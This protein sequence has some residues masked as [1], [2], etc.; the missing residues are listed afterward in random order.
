MIS[1]ARS[2]CVV[3]SQPPLL[4]VGFNIGAD[5]NA[6]KG[7]AAMKKEQYRLELQAQMRENEAKKMQQKTG[8]VL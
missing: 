7:P 5:F 4:V 2:T 8:L 1:F 6:E 3:V